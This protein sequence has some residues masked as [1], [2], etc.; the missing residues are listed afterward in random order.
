[1]EKVA[2]IDYF[3]HVTANHIFSGILTLIAYFPH[4]LKGLSSNYSS[5]S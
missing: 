3:S 4:E 5:A 1:M 2:I